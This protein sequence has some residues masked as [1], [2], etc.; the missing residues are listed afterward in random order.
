MK[1]FL[2]L[3][4]CV[5]EKV[6]GEIEK[7]KEAIEKGKEIVAN[8][9]DVAS[10]AVEGVKSKIED[11]TGIS[12]DKKETETKPEVQEVST[13]V[14]LSQNTQQFIDETPATTSTRKVFDG[15]IEKNNQL[16]PQAVAQE[17]I[18]TATIESIKVT[19]EQKA[20]LRS[21]SR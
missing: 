9:K 11:K 4:I 2:A 7:G 16:D 13:G 19:E 20:L 14:S 8:A 5:K 15:A 10:G 6:E 1:N 3:P 21:S 12:L 17:V 18:G